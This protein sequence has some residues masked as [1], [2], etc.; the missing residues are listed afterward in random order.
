MQIICPSGGEIARF[1]CY[2]GFQGKCCCPKRTAAKSS[3]SFA[4]PFA[5][6]VELNLH[7]FGRVWRLV[8]KDSKLE[9]LLCDEA[10]HRKVGTAK[11][12]NIEYEA[13]TENRYAI[14][15]ASGFYLIQIFKIELKVPYRQ[16]VKRLV[17]VT[18]LQ[19]YQSL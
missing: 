14:Q 6:I 17:V 15:K 16:F 11:T 19:K 18:S 5:K 3:F 1:A 13:A 4:V 10:R 8:E 7:I 2:N 9:F 12:T